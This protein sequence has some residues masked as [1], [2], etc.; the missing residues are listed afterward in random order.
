[1]LRNCESPELPESY[2]IAL[3][4]VDGIERRITEDKEFSDAYQN[5]IE[6]HVKENYAPKAATT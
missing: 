6:T 5:V 1:M 3:K 2:N 4:R